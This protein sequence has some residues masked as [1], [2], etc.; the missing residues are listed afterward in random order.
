M[1]FME[2]SLPE[3]AEMHAGPDGGLPEISEKII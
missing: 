1:K 2:F 3:L